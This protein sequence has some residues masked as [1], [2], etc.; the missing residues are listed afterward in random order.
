[1]AL[2]LVKNHCTCQRLNRKHCDLGPCNIK[3]TK[4]STVHMIHVTNTYKQTN[5]QVTS[6]FSPGTSTV[7]PT[8]P[9]EDQ[10]QKLISSTDFP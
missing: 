7:Q 2:C 4:T 6:D 8:G 5:K 1:M 3:E 10:I 9:V